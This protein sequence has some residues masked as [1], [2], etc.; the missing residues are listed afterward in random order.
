VSIAAARIDRLTELAHKAAAAGNDDRA[1]EYVGLARRIAERNR[2]AL[3]RE[4]K[5][6]SCSRCDRYLRPG[7][8]A[9]VRLRGSH[10]VVTCECGTH[11]RYPYDE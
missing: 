10:L 3:P 8:N 5:R 1:R 6:F 9:R 2:L 4:L 11:S 7:R